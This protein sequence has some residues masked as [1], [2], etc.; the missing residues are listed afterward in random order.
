[1][2]ISPDLVWLPHDHFWVLASRPSGAEPQDRTECCLL[3][4]FLGVVMLCLVCFGS[5]HTPWVE[6]EGGG[7]HGEL[8]VAS[9]SWQC[10]ATARLALLCA[11]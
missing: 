2:L 11:L 1:M 8:P 5:R 6:L 3:Q 4:R 9:V 7:P 10:W